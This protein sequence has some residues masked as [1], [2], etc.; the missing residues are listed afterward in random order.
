MADS[1][2]SFRWLE[3]RN[4]ISISLK[5]GHSIYRVIELVE[6]PIGPEGCSGGS[7]T[8]PLM[9]LTPNL[10]GREWLYLVLSSASLW[11]VTDT[12]YWSMVTR[13]AGER[14]RPI[15]TQHEVIQAEAEA[16][17][18][19]VASTQGREQS[20]RRQ[21]C[22]SVLDPR[23]HVWLADSNEAPGRCAQAQMQSHPCC[24]SLD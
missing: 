21:S 13:E 8:K 6:A 7:P 1:S 12:Q 20:H 18:R 2:G 5:E 24:C 17:R 23:A 10:S 11:K 9:V 22:A 4:Q 19:N 15:V 14:T 16:A 3:F